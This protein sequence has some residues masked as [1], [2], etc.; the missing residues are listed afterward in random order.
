MAFIKMIHPAEAQG[1]LREIY[2][3]I[4]RDLVGW[5]PVP[6]GSSVWNIMRIF[7]LRPTLLRTFERAFLLTMWGGVLRREAKEALGVTVSHTNHCHY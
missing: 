5:C 4:H 3:E 7:S 6:L 2:R 1:E